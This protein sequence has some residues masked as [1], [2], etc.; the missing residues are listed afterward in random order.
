MLFSK[1]TLGNSNVW[2]FFNWATGLSLLKLISDVCKESTE[3]PWPDFGVP[4]VVDP[5]WKLPFVQCPNQK[6][7]KRF[8]VITMTNINNFDDSVVKP[9]DHGNPSHSSAY[10]SPVP[11]CGVFSSELCACTAPTGAPI[12]K[13]GAGPWG[14]HAVARPLLRCL[15]QHLLRIQLIDTPT[16]EFIS[17][18]L[19]KGS[20]R[21]NWSC[22]FGMICFFLYLFLEVAMGTGI[23]SHEQMSGLNGCST[24]M[25]RSFTSY[26]S[27][28]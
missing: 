11:A 22:S 6:S 3:I 4:G 1:E 27:V 19:E 26:K 28:K 24:V 14:S 18:T 13:D 17:T 23:P 20:N 16:V 7:Q 8:S 9:H 12:C 25:V 15:G 10:L 5:Q 2:C 21:L